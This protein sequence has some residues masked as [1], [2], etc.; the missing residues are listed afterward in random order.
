MPFLLKSEI[1][2]M[3]DPPPCQ[4]GGRTT[5]QHFVPQPD[6]TA[7][8]GVQVITWQHLMLVEPAANAPVLELIIKATGEDCVRMV[9]TDEAG[10]ELNQGVSAEMMNTVEDVCHLPGGKALVIELR[11]FNLPVA[12][13]TALEKGQG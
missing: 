1:N 9:V 2:F 8:L 11:R 10:I 7:D 6:A 3:I 5:E 13:A 4:C 12:Q